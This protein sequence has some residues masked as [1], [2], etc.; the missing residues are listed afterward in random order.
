[1]P[2]S[3]YS[4]DQK[5]IQRGLLKK[6]GAANLKV[7]ESTTLP[8]GTS[9]A[10]TG[11]KEFAS[12]Q[13]SHDPGQLWVLGA[14]VSLL[15]GLLG[16]LLL[17]RERVFARVATRDTADPGGGGTVLTLASLTRGSGDSAPRFTALKDD[18]ADALVERAAERPT[19]GRT[20]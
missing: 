15:V 7:G 2:Q 6:V 13:L 16:M 10:F 14:A 1:V 18:L 8:D 20:P 4:L 19:G 9:I 5:E 17:R 12:L 11:Y 3:V